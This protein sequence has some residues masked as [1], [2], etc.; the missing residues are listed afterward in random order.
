MPA[1]FRFGL[2]P[3]LEHRRRGERDCERRFAVCRQEIGEHEQ[4]TVRL[5]DALRTQLA[6]PRVESSLWYVEDSL[7]ARRKA[8]AE[9]QRRLE[10]LRDE[11]I[12]ARRER[13]VI[14]KLYERRRKAYEAELAR[15]EEMEL[16]E[17]NAA[18]HQRMIRTPER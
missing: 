16:D 10:Q 15:Y 11:L 14:E 18:L 12:V 5:C 6:A 1:K 3:L 4:A 13:R 7:T 17:A 8:G 9:A 2:A